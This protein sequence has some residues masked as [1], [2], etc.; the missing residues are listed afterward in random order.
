[1]AIDLT[2]TI[3]RIITEGAELYC[4]RRGSGPPLLLIMGGI[5]DAGFYSSAANILA[6][7]FTVLNYDRRCNSRSTGDRSIDMTVAQQARD[8]IA[9]IKAMGHDKAIIFGSSG[10][11]II[12]LELAAANPNVIDFLIVHEPPVIGMKFDSLHSLKIIWLNTIFFITS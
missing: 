4:E 7:E 8:A 2:P 12:G 6:N 5:G 10:G 9:I 11:G 1:M 3:E